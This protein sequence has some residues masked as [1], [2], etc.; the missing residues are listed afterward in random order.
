MTPGQRLKA[1][2]ERRKLTQEKLAEMV[3]HAGMGNCTA[4][5]ISLFENSKLDPSVTKIRAVCRAL[6]LTPM[7]LIG[8]PRR[9]HHREPLL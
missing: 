8:D 5:W 3:R 9:R 7:T 4:G 6:D 2:R 1:I